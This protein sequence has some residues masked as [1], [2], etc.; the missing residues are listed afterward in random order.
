MANP[1]QAPPSWIAAVGAVVVDGRGCVLLVRRGRPPSLGAWTLPGGRVEA[2]ESYEDA[3]TR[4]V[5]EETA[6]RA[7]VI[8][9]LGLVPIV[10]EGFAYAIHEYLLAPFDGAAPVAGDDAAE[11]CWAARSDLDRL[12]LSV[13][14][15]A[16]I[17]RGLAFHRS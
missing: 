1:P 5:R 10:R 8:A 13:E 16:V 2:G 17:D 14:V 11:V 9:S 3:V 4:E 12:G 6:I 15:A 7:R